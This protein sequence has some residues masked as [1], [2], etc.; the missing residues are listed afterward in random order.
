[1]PRRSEAGFAVGAGATVLSVGMTGSVP[2]KTIVWCAS[3]AGA[4]QAVSEGG[5]VTVF[6]KS[7][8]V[9]ACVGRLGSEMFDATWP[10]NEPAQKVLSSGA[11][12]AP[13]AQMSEDIGSLILT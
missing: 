6:G 11:S 8:A 2:F 5:P 7:P 12:H 10:V 9:H 1:L 4:P 3:V 13:S